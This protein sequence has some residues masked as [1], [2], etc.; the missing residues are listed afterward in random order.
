MKSEEFCYWFQDHLKIAFKYDIDL[1]Y[2]VEHQK[3]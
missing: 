1:K 3:K 2:D